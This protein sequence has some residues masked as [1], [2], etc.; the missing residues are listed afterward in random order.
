MPTTGLFNGVPPAEPKKPAS[1]KVKIPPSEATIQYDEFGTVDGAGDGAGVGGPGRPA[2]PEK[3]KTWSVDGASRSPSPTEGV[4]KSFASP[5]T[6]SVWTVAP[7]VGSRASRSLPW[8]TQ[9]RPPASIGG[10]PMSS[11]ACHR[12]LGPGLVW[13]ASTPPSQ[14]M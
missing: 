1:P 11:P 6:S 3:A 4:G 5:P 10:A 9:S 7:V 13:M 12:T 2:E 14:G 8:T